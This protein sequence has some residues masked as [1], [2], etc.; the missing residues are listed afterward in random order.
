MSPAV[1]GTGFYA[2]PLA[3]SVEGSYFN[4]KTFLQLVR[5]QV[6]LK[7]S[8]LYASGRLFSVSSV[9]LTETPP[10]VTGALQMTAYYF[11]P[12]AAPAAPVTTTTDTTSGP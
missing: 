3:V 11:A 8:R 2:V 7:N 6:T 5:G 12:T 10:T 1:A 9:Q 4:V